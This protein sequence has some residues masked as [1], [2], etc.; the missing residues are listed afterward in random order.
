MNAGVADE[1][2]VVGFLKVIATAAAQIL[3]CSG[4]SGV[5]FERLAAD[6]PRPEVRWLAPLGSDTIAACLS[7][8]LGARRAGAGGLAIRRGGKAFLGVRLPSG[9]RASE[10]APIG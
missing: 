10:T 4:C 6:A 7:R 2:L 3:E 9:E 1:E 8:A 5:F